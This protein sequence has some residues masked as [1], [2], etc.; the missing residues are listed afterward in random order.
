M[1]E[2]SA[3]IVKPLGSPTGVVEDV[4]YGP[5]SVQNL[6]KGQDAYKAIYNADSLAIFAVVSTSPSWTSFVSPSLVDFLFNFAYRR[7]ISP[8]IA[9]HIYNKMAGSISAL[10]MITL[11]S[12]SSLPQRHKS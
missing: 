2:I 7:C 1:N 8:D 5:V 11:S 12:H 4:I 9:N 10:Q 3:E 6:R